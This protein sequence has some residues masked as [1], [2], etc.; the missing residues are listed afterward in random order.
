MRDFSSTLKV[1][2]V[3]ISCEY[4][5]VFFDVR[6]TNFAFLGVTFVDLDQLDN[7]EL[8]TMI[9]E[10]ERLFTYLQGAEGK[11]SIFSFETIHTSLPEY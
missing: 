4:S 5:R 9:F 2:L 10:A 3:G 7:R 6:V 8:A 11:Y 1:G